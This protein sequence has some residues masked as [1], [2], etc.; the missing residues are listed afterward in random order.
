MSP[1]AERPVTKGLSALG[2]VVAGRRSA[3]KIRRFKKEFLFFF[4]KASLIK[5]NFKKCVVLTSQSQNS[6]A[7]T[8]LYTETFCFVLEVKSHRRRPPVWSWTLEVCSWGSALPVDGTRLRGP[9]SPPCGP[10][11]LTVPQCPKAAVPFIST[12]DPLESGGK[13]CYMSQ[14]ALKS[15]ICTMDTHNFHW[16]SQKHDNIDNN[17]IQTNNNNYLH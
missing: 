17:G 16:L 9:T 12:P 11:F 7:P 10:T 4:I 3:W 1:T 13:R 14:A 6:G 2:S 5:K 8:V 15:S